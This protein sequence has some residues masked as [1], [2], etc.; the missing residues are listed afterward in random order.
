MIDEDGKK[1]FLKYKGEVVRS[2]LGASTLKEVALNSAGG[3]YLPVRTRAFDLDK[4]YS[5]LVLAAQKREL[6][7]TTMMQYDERFQVFLGAGI[8]LL[9]VELLLRERKKLTTDFT[10]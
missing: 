2:K 7:E 1:T 3:T 6:E 4:I 5:D 8:F 9:I 10:D